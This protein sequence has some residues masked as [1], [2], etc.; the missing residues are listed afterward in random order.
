[1]DDFGDFTFPYLFDN[2]LF[3]PTFIKNLQKRAA[4]DTKVTLT[5][6]EIYFVK[7]EFETNKVYL[8]ELEELVEAYRL[9]IFDNCLE[10]ILSHNCIYQLEKYSFRDI[11]QLEWFRF[12]HLEILGKEVS[13]LEHL[14]QQLNLDFTEAHLLNSEV[15]ILRVD[16]NHSNQEIKDIVRNYQLYINTSSQYRAN[17]HRARL[18]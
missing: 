2:Y 14:L 7:R 4:S 15:H 13:K 12:M 17:L 6:Q 5:P 1:M 3:T 10:E 8:K 9:R 16:V 18:V 11:L